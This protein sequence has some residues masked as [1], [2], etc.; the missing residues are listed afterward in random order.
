[1]PRIAGLADEKARLDVGHDGR[2]CSFFANHRFLRFAS[3][4]RELMRTVV[5]AVS[6][7]KNKPNSRKRIAITS[8]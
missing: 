2:V 7:S 1:V 6:L 3:C 5:S 8:E 4:C